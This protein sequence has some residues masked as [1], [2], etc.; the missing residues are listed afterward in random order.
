LPLGH[1]AQQQAAVKHRVAAN[2]RHTV[3]TTP[4]YSEHT[5]PNCGLGGD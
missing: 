3:R 2:H 1:T 4:R 5:S